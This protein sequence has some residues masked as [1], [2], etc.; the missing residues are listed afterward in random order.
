[1]ATIYEGGTEIT[2]APGDCA[3]RKLSAEEPGF[4]LAV[5]GKTAL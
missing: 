3:K 2:Y 5:F 4:Q 1:M